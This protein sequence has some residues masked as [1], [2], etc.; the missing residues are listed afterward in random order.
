M[1]QKTEILAAAGYADAAAVAERLGV[2]ESQAL[3]VMNQYNN[4]LVH[5]FRVVTFETLDQIK[6]ARESAETD[7]QTA[8]KRNAAASVW[9]HNGNAYEPVECVCGKVCK[10]RGALANHQRSCVTWQQQNVRRMQRER[11]QKRAAARKAMI[12]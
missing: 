2:S 10:G 11:L 8:N 3:R 9:N 12:P 6:R 5:G 4:Q 7:R 1:S